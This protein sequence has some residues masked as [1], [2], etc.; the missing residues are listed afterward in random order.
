MLLCQSSP[1]A[2]LMIVFLRA[3]TDEFSWLSNDSL[4]Q[5]KG[6]YKLQNKGGGGRLL[7]MNNNDAHFHS[8]ITRDAFCTLEVQ[9]D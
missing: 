3:N 8:H 5:H 7:V 1:F 9:V 2:S 6:D 4:A